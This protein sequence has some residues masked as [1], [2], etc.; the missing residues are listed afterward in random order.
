[1]TI[2]RKHTTV[3]CKRV[4][5]SVRRNKFNFLWI[6]ESCS[7]LPLQDRHWLHKVFSLCYTFAKVEISITWLSFCQVTS[8]SSIWSLKSKRQ[9]PF[10]SRPDH[11]QEFSFSL[12]ISLCV[13]DFHTEFCFDS[14]IWYLSLW[15]IEICPLSL[16]I[17][18]FEHVFLL[19]TT[20]PISTKRGTKLP[21]INWAMDIRLFKWRAMLLSKGR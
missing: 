10:V 2:K 21:W 14:C 8:H 17:V 15:C 4:S 9:S 18:N 20:G 1:M 11:Y 7:K 19:R 13:N 5:Y 3:S 6:S 12:P 16:L